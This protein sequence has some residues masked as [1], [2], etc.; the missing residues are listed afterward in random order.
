MNLILQL[1]LADLADT[2]L[3]RPRQE[4]APLRPDIPTLREASS[5]EVVYLAAVVCTRAPPPAVAAPAA[6]IVCAVA[7][8][9][10]PWC[11]PFSAALFTAPFTLTAV[12]SASHRL[13]LT[14][15]A[16][17]SVAGPRR[18]VVPH[19][20]GH[21]LPHIVGSSMLASPPPPTEA[22]S[23]AAESYPISL[24]PVQTPLAPGTRT[25]MFKPLVC[26]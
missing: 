10:A 3:G 24:S 17:L 6:E 25:S 5:R 20:L 19:E 23:P 26:S 21:H 22:R 7:A 9:S 1:P 12:R 2:L 8:G 18:A 13:A 16:A 11:L 15:P 14:A 4:Q